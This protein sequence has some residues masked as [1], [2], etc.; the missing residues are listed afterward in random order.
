MIKQRLKKVGL[1]P[2]TLIHVGE[3]KCKEIITDDFIKID[4][5]IPRPKDS[6]I[7]IDIEEEKEY[8]DEVM[9]V[10]MIKDRIVDQYNN[11]YFERNGLPIIVKVD[12]FYE[13]DNERILFL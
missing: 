1:P 11:I 12:K 10:E 8:D 3:K 7:N 5:V 13:V 9:P 4:S 6:I 2:G